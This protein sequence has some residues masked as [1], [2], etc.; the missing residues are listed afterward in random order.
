[1]ALER[2]VA[3]ISTHQQVLTLITPL[4]WLAPRASSY[5][6]SWNRKEKM[7]QTLGKAALHDNIT[8]FSGQMF[9]GQIFVDI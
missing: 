6:N 8:V 3:K 9:S 5:T 4:D 7:K 2:R 1:M